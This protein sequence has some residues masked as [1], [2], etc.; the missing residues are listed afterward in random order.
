[1]NHETTAY[2]NLPVALGVLL[3]SM[4]IAAIPF[5]ML[6][7]QKE[8]GPAAKVQLRELVNDELGLFAALFGTL[9]VVWGEP[10]GDPIATM[11]VA[12][13]ILYG[14]I[15]LFRENMS[16]LIGKSP[17]P[18]FVRKIEAAALSVEG[19]LSLHKVMV[20]CVGPNQ[21]HAGFHIEVRRGLP[22]EEADRISLEVHKRV[23][24]ATGCRYCVI[25]VDPEGAERVP[26]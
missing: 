6:F 10:L 23:K 26:E 21:I 12:T 20:E 9:F 24:Q 16:F 7:K 1:V 25:H 17:G 11:V 22:V 4:V 13:V 8:R 19:V 5:V 3:V 15:G 2:Q 18:E 14:A